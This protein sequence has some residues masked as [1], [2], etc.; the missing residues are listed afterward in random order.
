MKAYAPGLGFYHDVLPQGQRFCTFFVP[1][2]W[3]TCLFE[4][5]PRV[6]WP[7]GMVR[8]GIVELTDTLRK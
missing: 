8:L 5:F 6:N 4:K 2:G 7:G 3:G 1:R